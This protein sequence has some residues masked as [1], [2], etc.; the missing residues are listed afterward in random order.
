MAAP[1]AIHE[2]V[3]VALVKDGWTITDDPYTIE[4]R[5]TKLFADLAAERPLAAE[6]GGL[7]IVVE[8]KSF[9]G[10]SP[11]RDLELAIGQYHIYRH[12]L[13]VTAPERRLYLAVPKTTYT[14]F[15]A[16]PAVRLVV[17]RSRVALLVVD[18]AQQ[19]VAKWIS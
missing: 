4:Y 18:V 2:V 1:D 7:K 3:K 11:F 5:D 8:V 15:F 19:E 10:P 14:E 9:L 17:D 6:R 16:R 13:E 12:L